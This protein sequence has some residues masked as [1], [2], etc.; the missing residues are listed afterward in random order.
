MKEDRKK[1][2]EMLV[3]AG[4]INDMQ[5]SAAIGEQTKW[6]GKICS[7][8]VNRGFT[9]EEAIASVLEKQ[10]GQKAIS[11]RNRVIA[12]EILQRVSCDIARKYNV[13]PIAADGKRLTI[14]MAD[15]TDLQTIDELVFLLGT[16]IKP[17][18]A[19][20][21]ILKS[22]IDRFYDGATKESKT[23]KGNGG[24]SRENPK[25]I[26]NGLDASSVQPPREPSQTKDHIKEDR[27]TPDMMV[28]ALVRILIEKGLITKE[29]LMEKIREKNSLGV[30][31]CSQI[32]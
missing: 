6:G 9:S 28:E 22:A 17:V 25:S 20:E 11:F 5:L 32:N 27:I 26:R 2:G 16:K 29:E 21:S 15:P 12:P 14:A 31:M 19:I 4:L 8:I 13:V 1:I 7:I 18:L 3:E 30:N 24:D 10:F 23:F